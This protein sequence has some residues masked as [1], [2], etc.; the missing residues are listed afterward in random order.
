MAPVRRPLAC[1]TLTAGQGTGT[2]ADGHDMRIEWR[3]DLQA[4]SFRPAGHQASCMIH[5]L[6]IR[7]LAGSLLTPEECLA[8]ARDQAGVL[9]AA[10]A[11]KIAANTLA[12]ERSL[13][14]TSRDVRRL[15]LRP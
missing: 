4:I 10:A 2:G 11:R 6:A 7:T 13:H 12:P 5:W 15:A 1:K 9:Q 14:L 8:F 3:N